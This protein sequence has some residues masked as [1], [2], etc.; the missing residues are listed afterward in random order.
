MPR[1]RVDRAGRDAA[2]MPVGPAA[3]LAAGERIQ[4]G[5]ERLDRPLVRCDL[6]VH[7]NASSKP[8]M[9]ALGWIDCP[10]CY[11]EPERVYDQAR[12][13]GMD[14]VAVTDHDTIAGAMA[15][16]ERGYQGVIVGQEVSVQ[17]PEDRCKLHVL[18][19]GLTPELDEQLAGLRLREDVYAFAGWLRQHNLAHSLAHPLYSQNG[20]LTRRH[21]DRCVL[22]FRAFEVLNGAHAGEHRTALE[23]YLESITPSVVHRMVD[24]EG[25]EP[26]WPRVWEKVRTAGSDD[27]GL[28]NIGRTWTGVD[29]L[30]GDAIDGREFL[31][32]VMTGRAKVGG[33]GGHSSLLAHQLTTVAANYAG[34]V[35]VPRAGARVRF[36]A[37]KVLRFAGVDVAGPS[38]ASLAWEMVKRK[39]TRRRGSRLGPLVGAVRSSF[40]G[41]LARYPA[42]A[43][44]LEQGTWDERVGDEPARGHGRVLR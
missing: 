25:F 28:L 21:L 31:K 5:P 8:A 20:K 18:V 39:L 32:R 2:E 16:I 33:V 44:R 23:R 19:W 30:K 26:L 3:E 24:A 12:A 37:G 10:E 41:V 14:L 22:L 13:R 4:D 11:S 35:I 1:A 7:T 27:H 43:D 17:F 9:R 15:L 6:H 38:A 36:A 29:E 40:A 42:I 34:R